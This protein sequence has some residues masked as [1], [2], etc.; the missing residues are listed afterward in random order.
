MLLAIARMSRRR[1]RRVP[2]QTRRLLFESLEKRDLLAVA[3]QVYGLDFSPYINQ[4]EDPNKGPGQI[5]EQEL[6]ERL[7]TS[8]AYTD[9]GLRVFS[10]SG[11]LAP[12]GR[13]AHELGKNVAGGAWIGRD[14]AAN[15]TEI[16]ALVSQAIAGSIDVAI[17]GSEALLR[18]DV[19][20]ATLIGYV[21]DVKSRLAAANIAIPVTTADV[22]S[23]LLKN[24]GVVD[25][26]DVVFVNYY[27][28]WEGS[29]VDTAVARLHGWHQQMTDMAGTKEVVVSETGWPSGGERLGDAVP[30]PDNA[31]YYFLNFASWAQ[32]NR[33]K[34]FYFEAINEPW[35]GNEGVLGTEWGLLDATLTLKP[36]MERVFNGE[37]LP[38]NWTNPPGPPIIDFF[39]LPGTTNT[40]VGT[41]IVA[42]T[43]V[44][45]DD[46][47]KL[48]GIVIPAEAKDPG[49]VFAIAVPL[50][51]ARTRSC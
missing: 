39:S 42:G 16:D 40:N 47:V 34:Y 30:S 11:D 31:A 2:E 12:V 44:H 41:F 45:S 27:P 7:T 48:N 10:V 23:V 37:R 32:A 51:S 21:N 1:A 49:G 26:V 46:V 13:I 15:Q 5:T 4:G 33:V 35:K 3:Y 50:N 19:S 24:P 6:R 17:V 28:F 36:G 8:A 18:N 38:D 25:A 29:S 20:A 9:W 14:P 43:A 22:Y